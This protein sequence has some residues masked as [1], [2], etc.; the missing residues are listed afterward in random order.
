MK[1]RLFDTSSLLNVVRNKNSQSIKILNVQYILGLTLYEVLNV[2]WKLSYREKKIT[3]EQASTLL[4]SI[5]LLIQRMK[6][7]DINGLERRVQELAIQEGLTAYD[8]SYLAVAEK[9][10]LV[11]VTD[12]REL[13]RVAR[14]YVKVMKTTDL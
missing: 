13:E 4:D 11:L 12:D 5:L 7:V 3:L 14:K 9:L 1:D 2:I 6:I 10:D 8:A